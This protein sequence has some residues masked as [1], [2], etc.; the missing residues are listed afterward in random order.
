VQEACLQAW[1]ALPGFRAEA[2]LSTWL[3]RIAINE[4]LQRARRRGAL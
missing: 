2:R 1:R 3:V 4:A